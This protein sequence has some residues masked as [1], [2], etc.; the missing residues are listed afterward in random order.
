MNP[1]DGLYGI[2]TKWLFDDP[3]A[4]S[5]AFQSKGETPFEKLFQSRYG[6][7]VETWAEGTGE[8]WRPFVQSIKQRKK[9][10][11]ISSVVRTS[12]ERAASIT[13]RGRTQTRARPQPQP[14]SQPPVMTMAALAGGDS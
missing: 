14:Q 4:A 7:S 12:R 6:M 9:Q 5:A 1:F 3:L 11:R 8:A 10:E 13:S 2:N